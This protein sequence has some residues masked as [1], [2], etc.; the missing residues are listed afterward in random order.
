[1]FCGGLR[2]LTTARSLSHWPAAVEK[3]QANKFEGTQIMSSL[4][5]RSNCSIDHAIDGTDTHTHTQTQK[6]M[7]HTHPHTIHNIR[8]NTRPLLVTFLFIQTRNPNRWNT[9]THK[10][11]EEKG[12]L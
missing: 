7:E 6:T 9:F 5:I 12:V 4:L 10:R 3:T 11:R 2:A 8:T 1:M